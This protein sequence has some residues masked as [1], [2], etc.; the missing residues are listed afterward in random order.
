MQPESERLAQTLSTTFGLRF[1][2]T[3]RETTEGQLYSI[4]PALLHPHDGF[5]VNVLLGWRSVKAEFVPGA[6]AQDLIDEM[7]AAGEGEKIAFQGVAKCLVESEMSLE[8]RLNGVQVDPL[9]FNS[10]PARAKSVEIRVRGHPFDRTTSDRERDYKEV[11]TVTEGSLALVLALVAEPDLGGP[12]DPIEMDVAGY[13]EGAVMQV[14]TN[15]YER[16]TRNRALSIATHG[17]KCAVCG[18]E[19]E[20]VYGDIGAGYIHVHHLV[21]LSMLGQDYK[22]NPTTDLIPVCPNCHAMLHRERPPLTI[23]ALQA[24]LQLRQRKG[25]QPEA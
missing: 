1:A 24:R 8:V 13:P 12:E 18:L 5:G 4:S 10:W 21:P 22:V 2:V 7:G 9:D 17:A 25:V 3:V 16:D 15:R 11:L 14:V 23:E 6:F 20:S 19:F